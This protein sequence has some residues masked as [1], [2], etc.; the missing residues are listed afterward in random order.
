M[1]RDDTRKFCS[2]PKYY[3]AFVVLISDHSIV[4]G[5]GGLTSGRGI[6]TTNVLS[7]P[8]LPVPPRL[9]VDLLGRMPSATIVLRPLASCYLGLVASICRYGGTLMPKVAAIDQ[10]TTQIVV[11]VMV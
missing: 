9:Q 10:I 5:E 11:P 8:R 1:V 3:R 4:N 7:T 6:V 2:Q